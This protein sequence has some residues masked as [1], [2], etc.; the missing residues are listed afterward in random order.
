MSTT[1]LEIRVTIALD[2]FSQEALA[3]HKF[4]ADMKEAFADAGYGSCSEPSLISTGYF[5]FLCNLTNLPDGLNLLSERCKGMTPKPKVEV[6]L[7]GQD[8]YPIGL[9]PDNDLPEYLSGLEVG[10][11]FR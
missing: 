5:R 6:V 1:R 10:D 2:K 3:L 11:K 8:N 7:F 9:F 4:H